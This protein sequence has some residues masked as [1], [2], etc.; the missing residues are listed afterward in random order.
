[1]KLYLYLYFVLILFGIS[2]N[3][4]AQIAPGGVS[5]NNV[6]WVKATS[7]ITS[8]AGNVSNW[9]DNSL[10]NNDASQVNASYQPSFNPFFQNY[11]PAVYFDGTNEHLN[12][13]DLIN[14]TSK[15]VNVF[16]VGTNEGGGDLWHAMVSG[17][18][19]SQWTSGGYGLCSYNGQV[20]F[21]FWANQWSS[22]AHST[23]IGGP[24]MFAAILEGKYDGT[25]I[26][27]YKNATLNASTAFSQAIGDGGSTNLGGGNNTASNHKGHIAEVI[28]Y[29]TALTDADRHKINSYL[30]LKYGI[31][32]NRF[33]I[34]N[35]FLNSLGNSIYA[36]GGT[37]TYWHNVI[38]IGRDDNSTLYQKQSHEL[39]DNSRIYLN[40]LTTSN[41]TNSGTF[42]TDN[43]FLIMGNN[44]DFI[45]VTDAANTEKPAGVFARIERE[46][47]LTN[48]NFNTQ[49][50]ID[51]KLNICVDIP[52][53]N[54]PDLRLLLDDDGD[55]S[56]AAVYD[57]SAGL[58]ISISGNI[59][60]IT[61]LTSTH[62]PTN[63]TK[64]FTLASI[65][66]TTLDDN[67]HALPVQDIHTCDIN[68]N[69]FASFTTNIPN[70]ESQVVGAQTGLTV[71]YFDHLGNSLN[72]T[73]PFTN[74][75]INQQT[76]TVR[77][78]NSFGCYD[79]TTFDLI[80][81]P[82]PAVDSPSNLSRCASYT[83]P[84][85]T[86]GNYFTGVNGT[87]TALFVGD[88]ITTTQTIY[89]YANDGTCSNET[90]FVVTI[91]PL[92]AVDTINSFSACGNYTLD[93]LTNG[94]YF[95]GANGTGT[96]LFAGDNITTT[97]TL[98]I[99]ADDGTC[100]NETSFTLTINPLPA[101]SSLSSLDS[102]VTYV[103][104]N[105]ADGNYYTASGGTGTL[106][107]AGA[108]I[109]TTQTIY[110]YANNGTC[111]NETNFTVTIHPMPIVD[112]SLAIQECGQYVLP[113]LSNGNYFTETGGTG[114]ALFAGDSINTSQTIYIYANDGFCTNETN[115][116]VV[117]IPIIPFSL[118]LD[119]I[120]ISN[121]NDILITMAD[122]GLIYEYQLDNLNFQPNNYYYDLDAGI[123]TLTVKDHNGCEIHSIYFYITIFDIP[124]YFTPN[125][126]GYHDFWQV[127]DSA[128]TIVSITIY[129]RYGKIL[130]QVNPNTTGWNGKF[131]GVNLPSDDYWYIITLINKEQLRG[132]FSL[133]R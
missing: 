59:V 20:N 49:F 8:T 7:G 113:T 94:N 111:S 107:N 85:L 42:T 92:P 16:A 43:Q 90:S 102:C 110:I 76:I 12:I 62:F 17:Q 96:A 45:S 9:A 44:S 101:V 103:L 64:Y 32:P 60:S 11:N 88:T 120:T 91:N 35:N 112:H 46:W 10:G 128:N 105:I 122:L 14:P 67:F 68:N 31:T 1:M 23:F 39:W 58:N 84:A 38:G 129:D 100:S 97:Q 18:T 78:T 119:N 65:N 124:H 99:Y 98:Y 80:I 47:K 4:N 55:F 126:D 123:H 52:Q 114:T 133:K 19:D 79:E 40:N 75:V 116:D 132:H 41:T 21:G 15:N 73:D 54:A 109:T 95:T 63:S 131:N 61:G 48:T 3:T 87:G 56:N 118:A 6:F 25:S 108:I 70:I 34:A 81:D 74:T 71:S 115:F 69:G 57:S 28:I 66:N 36:S 93:S 51:I 127:E 2:I 37:N 82:L 29:D 24:A 89:V 83:L 13:N 104:P 72:L 106:L 30:A 130:K 50:N 86:N 26:N 33:A 22:N 5:A 121:Q 117:I 27:Y 53:I 77:V 125:G